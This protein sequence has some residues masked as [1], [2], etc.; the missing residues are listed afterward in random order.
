MCSVSIV[1]P[2]H[3]P[4]YWEFLSFTKGNKPKKTETSGLEEFRNWAA[5]QRPGLPGEA[6]NNPTDLVNVS[7]VSPAS[8]VA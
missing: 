1:I 4:V 5:A 6:T 8:P 2:I 7:A 3:Q